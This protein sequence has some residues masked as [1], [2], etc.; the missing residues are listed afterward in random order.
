MKVKL[1]KDYRKNYTLDDLDRAKKSHR[2]RKGK[3]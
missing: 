3:R 1:K 2:I